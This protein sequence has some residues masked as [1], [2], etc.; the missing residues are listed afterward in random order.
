ML[1]YSYASISSALKLTQKSD[2]REKLGAQADPIYLCYPKNGM[3]PRAVR[4]I[5]NF[6][7]DGED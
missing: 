6:F 2:F 7:S 4:A 3:G 1:A 5:M